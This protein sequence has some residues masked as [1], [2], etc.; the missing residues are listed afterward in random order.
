MLALHATSGE[1]AASVAVVSH[2]QGGEGAII[3]HLW[4]NTLLGITLCQMPGLWRLGI[5]DWRLVGGFRDSSKVPL[6]S[7]ALQ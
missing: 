3:F 6:Y 1:G 2:Q 4:H 5:S 7:V